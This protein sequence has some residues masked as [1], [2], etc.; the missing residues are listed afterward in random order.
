MLFLTCSFVNFVKNPCVLCGKN[1]GKV[2]HK[3]HKVNATKNT[4][5]MP[6][7]TQSGG[8][9]MIFFDLGCWLF[10][11]SGPTCGLNFLIIF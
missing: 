5:E 4:K 8:C 1:K 11:F 10:L 9:R 7:R 2:N 6:Q 3:V